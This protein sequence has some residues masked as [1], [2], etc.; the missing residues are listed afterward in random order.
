MIFFLISLSTFY[1]YFV[2]KVVKSI[3]VLSDVKYSIKKYFKKVKKEYVKTFNLLDLS[4]IILILIAFVTNEK[5]TGMCT[6][7]LYMVLCLKELKDKGNF[8]FNANN[9]RIFIITLFLFTALNIAILLDYNEATNMFLDYSPIFIYY[10]VLYI[11]M[12][13]IWIIVGI[14]GFMNNLFSKKSSKNNKKN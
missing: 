6:V 8:Q 13:F 4:F 5:V 7:I 12:Y 14:A 3:N 9:I 1:V 11:V 10:S 2:L